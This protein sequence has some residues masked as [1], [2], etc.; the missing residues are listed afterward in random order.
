MIGMLSGRSRRHFVCAAAVAAAGAGAWGQNLRL[1]E[2]AQ[3]SVFVRTDRSKGD[4]PAA[5]AR[6]AKIIEDLGSPDFKTRCRADRELSEDGFITLPMIERELKQR[7]DQLSLDTRERLCSAA[8]TRFNQTPRAAMGIQFWQN[9]NLRDRVVIERTFPKFDA[10]NKIEDGDMIIE[11][12]GVKIS[13]PAA[14]S[15]FQSVIVSHDPGD[16]IPLVI[17]RG[18]RRINTEVRLGRR[19]ELESN[20]GVTSEILERAWRVRAVSILGPAEKAI[21]PPIAP[22]NWTERPMNFRGD[23]LSARRKS[24]SIGGPTLVGGGMPRGAERLNAQ[25]DGGQ[26]AQVFRRNGQLVINGMVLVAGAGAMDPFAESAYPP[27]SPQEELAELTRA[28]DQYALVQGKAGGARVGRVV[29]DGPVI[30][31]AEVPAKELAIIEKQI[32]A[33]RAELVESGLSLPDSAAAATP[34]GP[35]DKLAPGGGAP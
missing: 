35:G 8:R 21:A 1:I 33:V 3:P 29:P 13:G 20:P 15:K 12:D 23:R 16:V 17:R 22:E 10:S 11:A 24:V 2:Q 5:P 6:L 32:S 26:Y 4:D 7:R 31:T 9:V 34:E 18:D 14:R 30:M 27:M 25:A 28:R 19:D